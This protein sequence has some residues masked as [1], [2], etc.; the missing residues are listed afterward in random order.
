MHLIGYWI[1]SL[2]NE[3]WCAP[4]EVTGVL[5]PEAR[6][7]LVEYLDAGEC[8]GH[9][10]GISWCRFACGCLEM[11]SKERTDGRW[12]WPEGLSHY[13]RLHHVVLPEEFVAHALELPSKT[14]AQPERESFWQELFT[15]PDRKP[16]LDYWENWCAAHRSPIALGRIRQARVEADAR[17]K[18]AVQR[19]IAE[20][21]E[22]HGLSDQ[23]CLFANC[24]EK[25]LSGSRICAVHTL[26]DTVKWVAEA[27]YSLGPETSV[28]LFSDLSSP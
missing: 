8:C 1:E 19:V 26:A 7:R 23:N 25:A 15:S 21:I 10:R 11:G 22:R 14:S 6:A 2:R 4:Q 18:D 17:A 24:N 9:F 28:R 13:V 27:C 20:E 3:R 5:E 16:R 12:V